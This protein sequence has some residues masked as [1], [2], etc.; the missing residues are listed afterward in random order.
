MKYTYRVLIDIVWIVCRHLAMINLPSAD[1]HTHLGSLVLQVAVLQRL[2]TH[3]QE[4]LLLNVNVAGLLPG[5]GE[6]LVVKL[7]QVVHEPSLLRDDL[8]RTLLVALFVNVETAVPPVLGDLL[9]TVPSLQQ[10]VE[11]LLGTVGLAWEAAAEA[12]D[13]KLVGSGNMIGGGASGD[14]VCQIRCV[15]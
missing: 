9:H 11:E 14:T 3:L 7:E 6:R 15:W 8:A 13:G 1:E 4:D 12:D 10:V 5:H 2:V